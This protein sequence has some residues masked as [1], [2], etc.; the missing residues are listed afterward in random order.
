MHVRPGFQLAR[1]EC[2]ADNDIVFRVVE[3]GPTQLWSKRRIL[4][5]PNQCLLFLAEGQ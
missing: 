3:N 1:I 5:D 2:D 4:D